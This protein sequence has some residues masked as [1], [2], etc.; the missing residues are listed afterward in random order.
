[1]SSNDDSGSPGLALQW[2][3]GVGLC[4][5]GCSARCRRLSLLTEVQG[6]LA[7]LELCPGHTARNVCPPLHGIVMRDGEVTGQISVNA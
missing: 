6:K 3:R 5:G 7:G 2:S 4:G 1:M